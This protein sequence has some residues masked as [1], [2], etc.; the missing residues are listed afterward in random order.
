MEVSDSQ[1]C[2]PKRRVGG[3]TYLLVEKGKDPPP[4]TSRC[5]D[6]CAYRLDLQWINDF[7]IQVFYSRKRGAS[8]DDEFDQVFCFE[9]G[10]LSSTCLGRYF[11]RCY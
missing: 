11:C 9:R 4:D 1:E 10:N 3:I 5:S 8:A 7:C 6:N 2:C